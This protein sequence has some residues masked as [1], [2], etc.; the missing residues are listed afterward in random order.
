MDEYKKLTRN[1]LILMSG[2]MGSRV[3][4]FLMI[5]FY[6][7]ILSTSEYGIIDLLLQ[8]SNF[9]VPLCTIGMTTGIIR[10]GLDNRYRQKD[11]FSISILC[12]GIGL[13]LFLIVALL[14]IRFPLPDG[15][16]SYCIW[17]LFLVAASGLN[18]ICG[19]FVRALA[20]VKTFARAGI[21]N[22]VTNVLLMI[23]FL[24]VLHLGIR[25]YMLSVILA[26]TTTMLFLFISSNL[27]K[28]IQFN[29]IHLSTTK[30]V[31]SFSMPTIPATISWWI[32]DMSDRLMITGFISE[33][34]NGI[35]SIAA[36]IP[37]IVT[38]ISNSFISAW[39][40][41][42]I[43][44]ENKE[45]QIRLYSNV[46]RTYIAILFIMAS[47]VTSISHLIVTFLTSASFYAAEKYVPLLIGATVFSCLSTFVGNIYVVVKKSMPQF[48][49]T[50]ISA[51]C[52]VLLNGLLIPHLG[53]Y[54]AVIATFIS[55]AL[56]FVIRIVNTRKYMKLEWSPGR[57]VT[58]FILLMIQIMVK[59]FGDGLLYIIQIICMVG[60]IILNFRPLM[61]GIQ[62]INPFK[63]GI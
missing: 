56:L 35:Y 3:V 58:S 63:R 54:G 30:E 59:Q 37:S 19:A 10:F 48:I 25:G 31:L 2:T 57:F 7:N 14:M 1:T 8:I 18:S 41:S 24:G 60:I 16:E 6:T 39:Q 53:T 11:V 15:I 33:S 55:F 52:N 23:L 9:I 26:D 38:I 45:Q 13:L 27:W 17:I 43:G 42:I 21:I 22:T 40:I 32:I 50:I 36:R 28:Y 46:I 47:I 20:K 44:T 61:T 34:A 5:R 62:K 12:F 29:G 51:V 49:T 4:S